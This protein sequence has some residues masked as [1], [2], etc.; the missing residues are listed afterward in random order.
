MKYIIDAID[1]TKGIRLITYSVS[2]TCENRIKKVLA[3]HLTSHECQPLL[4]PIYTCVKELLINAV[5]AN[6]KNLY[7]EEAGATA[8]IKGTIS[9]KTALQLF[10]ME[11]TRENTKN[12]ARIAKEKNMTA[13]V[14]IAVNGGILDICVRNPVV[15]TEDEYKRV[16]RKLVDANECSDITEYFLSQVDDPDNEGAG[17]GLVLVTMILKSLGLN[18]SALT[19]ASGKDSTKAEL[20]IPL[21]PATLTHFQKSVAAA[22]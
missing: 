7:F 19:I 20:R 12:L 9:Q 1:Q 4:T 2:N 13:D 22:G 14:T 5:K 6:Y 17:I 8:G 16:R 21:N 11:I 15:M 3:L 10:K 18:Q